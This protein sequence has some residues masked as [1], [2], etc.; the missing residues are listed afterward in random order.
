MKVYEILTEAGI[1]SKKLTHLE[2]VEDV[3]LHTGSAGIRQSIDFLESVYDFL[4]GAKTNNRFVTTLKIDGSMALVFGKDPE[5]GKFFVGTKSVFNKEPKINFTDA[6]IKRNHPQ[7]GVQSAL[8]AALKVLKNVPFKSI[9]QGDLL[10]RQNE[11]STS[12]VHGEKTIVFTPNTLSY[13]VPAHTPL[14]KKVKN[15][16]LGIAIHTKYSG[17]SITELEATLG[18]NTRDLPKTSDVWL[19][20]TE[21]DDLTGVA[22]LT[23][24]EQQLIRKALSKVEFFYKKLDKSF[25]DS[26]TVSPTA[27]TKPI[28]RVFAKWYNGVIKAGE[29][30]HDAEELLASLLDYMQA[31][32]GERSAALKTEKGRTKLNAETA[33]TVAHIAQY[34][35]KFLTFLQLYNAMILAKE[36]LLH[37]LNILN[38]GVS[39]Y[40]KHSGD[41]YKVTAPEGFVVIKDRDSKH[42]SFIKLVDRWTFSHQNAKSAEARGLGK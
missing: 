1:A 39:T 27:E 33:T 24:R 2:H 3:M 23:E 30:T 11:L 6:D 7:P 19:L 8:S 10:Y 34:K 4:L 35:K 21:I 37:K 5:T 16:K 40:I 25:I 38:N 36:A 12:V 42:R 31:H 15:S 26:V 14:G 29:K 18:V 9:Y 41:E 28:K 13:G 22:K 32:E 20:P 17:P